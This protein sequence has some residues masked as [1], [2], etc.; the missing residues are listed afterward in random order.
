MKNIG[1]GANRPQEALPVEEK[2]Q[3]ETNHPVVIAASVPAEVIVPAQPV[4]P[5]PRV[6]VE[7]EKK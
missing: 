3:E 5:A 7:E 1:A 6:A 4:Q 2:K